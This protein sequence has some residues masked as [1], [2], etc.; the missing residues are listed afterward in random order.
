M[1]NGRGLRKR[2]ALRIITTVSLLLCLAPFCL[3][4]ESATAAIQASEIQQLAVMP[5]ITVSDSAQHNKELNKTLDC[6]LVGLCYLDRDVLTQSEETLTGQLSEELVNYYADAL[7]PQPLVTEHYLQ[8][9]KDPQETPRE[10]AIRLGQDL[11]ADHVMVGLIWQYRQRVGGA[12]SADSPASVAFSLFLVDVANK[13][14]V[15]EGQFEKTQRA[16]SDNLF[17]A[18]LFFTSGVK[19]LSAEELSQYGM[20]QT[21]ESLPAQTN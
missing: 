6:Q 16:L 17:D 4:A 3:A 21:L 7:L 5:F 1:N 12:L 10:L 8:Q 13:N 18:A 14:L 20:E 2:I 11:A 15:W 9:A 19:W